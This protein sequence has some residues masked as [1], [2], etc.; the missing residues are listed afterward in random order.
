MTTLS[1]SIV[2]AEHKTSHMLGKPSNMELLLW[3]EDLQASVLLKGL[4]A[5]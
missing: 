2:G 3:P 4:P 1:V 5:P